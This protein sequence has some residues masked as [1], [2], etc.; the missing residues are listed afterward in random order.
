MAGLM[1]TLEYP[2]TYMH[3]TIIG[4]TLFS[5]CFWLPFKN[6]VCRHVY[7]RTKEN[8]D[9]SWYMLAHQQRG[10]GRGSMI[11]GDIHRH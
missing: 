6:L 10:P 9:V 2:Y 11:T 4:R 5:N 1:V 7:A 8:V 3:Q